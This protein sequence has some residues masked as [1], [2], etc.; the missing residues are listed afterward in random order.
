MFGSQKVEVELGLFLVLWD[1]GGGDSAPH[2]NSENIKA[3]TTKLKG[4]KVRQKMFS[5]RSA[6][7]ADDV[8]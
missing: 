3:M 1:L 8:I 7:S 6:T 5:V 4:Q 2:L